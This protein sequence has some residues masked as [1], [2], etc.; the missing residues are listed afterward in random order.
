MFVLKRHLLQVLTPLTVTAV[1]T[2]QAPVLGDLTNVL[3]PKELG[4]IVS[5]SL[6]LLHSTRSASMV[7]LTVGLKDS[8]SD[9]WVP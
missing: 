7:P 3:Y 6:T 5:L 4:L 2:A 8:R 9:S 1:P